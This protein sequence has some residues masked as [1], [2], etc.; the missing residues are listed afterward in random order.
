MSAPRA[1]RKNESNNPRGTG[2]RT[3]WRVCIYIHICVLCKVIIIIIIMCIMISSFIIIIICM[4]LS[5]YVYIHIYIYTYIHMYIRRPVYLHDMTCSR[6]PYAPF[7]RMYCTSQSIS[8]KV[9]KVMCM[10]TVDWVAVC[11]STRSHHL[12]TSAPPYC[13]TSIHPFACLSPDRGHERERERER[14]Q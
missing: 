7:V 12:W 13:H 2:S 5:L 8:S 6:A 3:A 10:E 1:V 14:E 11:I 4:D 9:N